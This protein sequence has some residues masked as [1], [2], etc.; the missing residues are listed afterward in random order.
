[1][2]VPGQIDHPS[3]TPRSYL[4]TTSTGQVRRN[5]RDLRP[6]PNHESTTETLNDHS[7]AQV[8][9]TRSRSGVVLNPPDRLTY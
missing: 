5:C 4:V 1:M 8:I 9:R 6:R 2:Q 7:Q 3:N